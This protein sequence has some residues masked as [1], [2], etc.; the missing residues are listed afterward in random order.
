M[1]VAIFLTGFTESCDFVVSLI[2]MD[3]FFDFSFWNNV[4]HEMRSMVFACLFVRFAHFRMF[5]GVNEKRD[6][7]L[8]V[9]RIEFLFVL[10]EEI[11]Q[12]LR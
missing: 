7:E 3:L 6:R 12:L 9:F 10:Y 1:K 5:H 8:E 11:M 2:F 4:L